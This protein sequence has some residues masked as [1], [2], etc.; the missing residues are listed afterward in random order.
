MMRLSSSASR[1]RE[2]RPAQGNKHNYHPCR[3]ESRQHGH[4]IATREM[5]ARPSPTRRSSRGMRW[6]SQMLQ[7]RCDH[8]PALCG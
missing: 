7:V 8:G 2:A 3:R 6:A 1:R 5:N 4:L